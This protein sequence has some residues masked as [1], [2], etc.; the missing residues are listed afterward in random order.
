MTVV[1]GS[2]YLLMDNAALD[3][4]MPTVMTFNK[5]AECFVDHDDLI[6][7]SMNNDILV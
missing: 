2:V 1:G 3:S 6:D 4:K 5:E 7:F